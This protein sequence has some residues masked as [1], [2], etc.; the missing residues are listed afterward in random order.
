MLSKECGCAFQL[1]G[2]LQ[3]ALFC[4]TAFPR[5]VGSILIFNHQIV[6]VNFP[7][8]KLF[9]I[10]DIQILLCQTTNKK[11]RLSN[12]SDLARWWLMLHWEKILNFY[13]AYYGAF[14]LI[15]V[16][17]LRVALYC[18]L[19]LYDDPLLNFI[20]KGEFP[21]KSYYAFS[22]LAPPSRFSIGIPLSHILSFFVILSYT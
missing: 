11:I 12:I 21:L 19:F 17:K 3:F 6:N 8:S 22:K 5:K 18:S 2:C 9:S 20:V 15:E 16:V 10:Q 7:N 13:G 4:S 1:S 14:E